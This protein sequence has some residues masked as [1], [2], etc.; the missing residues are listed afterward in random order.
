MTTTVGPMA[1]RIT[2]CGVCGQPPPMELLLRDLKQAALV[3]SNQEARYLVDYYYICQEDRKR[4]NLQRRALDENE[5]PNI[6]LVWV[7]DNMRRL[8][9]R[10]KAALEVYT[11]QSLVGQWSMSQVGIG[12]IIAAGL[13]AHV[14]L[15]TTPSCSALW[16]FAGLDPSVQWEK[17]QKRPWNAS[18]KVL[19]WKIGDSFVKTCNHPA[20]FY[21]PVYKKAKE[22]YSEQNDKGMYAHRAAEILQAKNFHQDTV[23]RQYYESGTL[24]PAHVHAMAKRKAVKLFLSHWWEVAYEAHHGT[25]PLNRP[26]VF[27]V[28]GHKDYIP[29][30]GWPL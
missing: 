2:V 9:T 25:R 20:S 4:A 18:L 8:E 7:A 14:S 11:N 13:L 24:P 6:L 1:P 16:A 27:D 17:G 29:P 30:P 26:Y 19:C 12:P 22:W 15:D 5:E 10:I 3:L 23:A 21:G 28:L